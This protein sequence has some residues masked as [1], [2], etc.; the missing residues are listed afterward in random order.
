GDDA[1][2]NA[3]RV[4][5]ARQAAPAQVGTRVARR[6]GGRFCRSGA[7]KRLLT[8]LLA[9]ALA[10]C[11][12]GPD[13]ERP[14]APVSAAYRE[15]PRTGD[16]VWLPA[17]PADL[18]A[19]GDWWRLFDD[20]ELDRLASEV[21]A[22]NQTVAAAVASYTQAQALVRET[23]AAYYPTVGIDAS[24]RRFGGGNGSAGSTGGTGT[25]TANAFSAS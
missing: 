4:R 17:A 20:A 6:H 25:G 2:D 12:V 8:S 16:A 21:D 5:R 7:M 19:R 22:A 23:R 18:L 9:S 3:G 14:S 13:Y 10:A 11:A 15:A 1:A 24:G